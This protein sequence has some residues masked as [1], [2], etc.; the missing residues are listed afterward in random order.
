MN[1]VIVRKIITTNNRLFPVK[2]LAL[3]NLQGI[4]ENNILK[5]T[6]VTCYADAQIEKVVIDF[7][8]LTEVPIKHY[9]V[10]TIKCE[11]SR[12]TMKVSNYHHC[13]REWRRGLYETT[14]FMHPKEDVLGTH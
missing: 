2:Q 6:S 8:D 10:S 11:I 4:R 5:I 3:E 12:R 14:G 9:T 13:P 7:A 1:I